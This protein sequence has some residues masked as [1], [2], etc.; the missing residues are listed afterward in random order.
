[1]GQLTKSLAIRGLM[2]APGFTLTATL[3]LA[4]GIGLSTAVFTV[5]DAILLRD[6]PVRDQ[7]RVVVLWGQ[8]RDGRFS[9]FPLALDDIREFQRRSRSLERVAFFAFRGATPEPIRSVDQ[10]YAVRVALVSGNFFDVLESRPVLGRALRP[11]DDVA[12]AAPVV[13]L[14]HRAWQQR[15]GGDSSIIGRS[16]TMIQTGRS[17]T[18][19]GVMPQGLEYPHG[20]EL[21]APVVASGAAGGFLDIITRELD[22]LARLRPDASAEQARA[23]LSAF[24]GRPEAPSWH[25]DV[26]GV[27]HS[28]SD[29]VLG[30]TR[31]SVLFVTLAAA[32]LLLITCINVAN[33]L[34]V[35]SLGRVREF[36]VRA[37]IGASRARLVAQLLSESAF[38][39]LAGGLLGIVLAI[40]CVRAF[41]IIAPETIPRLDEIGVNGTALLAALGITSI[42]MLASGLGPA[43]LSSRVDAQDALRSG[44]R[45]SGGTRVR[46]L[47]EVLVVA[48][49]ALA[50]VS[51]TT[52]GLVSRSLVKL[53][54]VDLAFEP[55]Q[56]LAVS[57]AMRLDQ[58]AGADNRRAALDAAVTAVARVPG[59]RDVSPVMAVPFVGAAGGID[60]RPSTPGQSR[61]QAA[62]NPMVNMEVAAPNHFAMLGIPVLRGRA[63]VDADREGAAPVI[64]V[65]SSVARHFWPDTD[66]I[67]KQI[68]S[69][70]RARTV[71]GVVPDTRYRE[72]RTARPTV[73]FPLRQSPFTSLVPSTLLVRASGEPGDL[74]PSLRRAVTDASPSVSVQS[75]ASLATLLEGPRAE[76]R[77]NAIVLALFAI[78]A[79]ALAAVGLFAVLA[80]L[81]RQR[82][83]EMGIRMAL[84][85]TAADTRST[86]M[87][88]G[89][90]LALSGA[91]L[92]MLGALAMGRML[93][94]LLFDMVATDAV[95]LVAVAALLVLVALIACFLPARAIMKI[96]PVI[97]LRS[98]T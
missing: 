56:L 97:A 11:D 25:R 44:S 21:W 37:A 77:L 31:T 51:L 45:S 28:L 33:L 18:I 20:T 82:T 67:G 6:L 17:Y 86:V 12:G 19:V 83:R 29:I 64:V 63:F 24:F 84:G 81:V 8:T 88:R 70:G 35:R 47:A 78:A 15:F 48:Q 69:P 42:A 65:S 79:V 73:Y 27:V 5:A 2:R 30:D 89:L 1:M 13:A 55:N 76:P 36:V 92:G 16:I 94:A 46:M 50:A 40:G 32:L 14:S 87:A 53:Q 4:M 72:L 71:V 61:E 66:P 34:L 59:V 85:A 41:V 93:S 26:R 60:G 22:V 98:E 90:F 62:A 43:L 68:G 57:L 74:V 96:D 75:A 91:A 39:S 58:L 95:T 23:E 9:N 38:L 3:T 10:T 7:D 52:A 54:R 80:T 49:I